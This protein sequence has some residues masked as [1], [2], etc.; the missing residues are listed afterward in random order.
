MLGLYESAI[1]SVDT[2]EAVCQSLWEIWETREN[3]VWSDHASD[4][5]WATDKWVERFT[6]TSDCTV[7]G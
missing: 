7:G 4:G 2:P 6:G 5:T 3:E 1:F